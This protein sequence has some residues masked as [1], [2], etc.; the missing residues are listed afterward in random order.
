MAGSPNFEIALDGSTLG[1]R[2]LKHLL[3]AELRESLHEMDAFTLSLVVPQDPTEVTTLAKPGS[4]F[5]VK[6]KHGDSEREIKGSIVEVS[7]ARSVSAPW[8]VTYIGLDKMHELTRKRAKKVRK[9]SDATVVKEIA[10]ECGVSAEV[11]DVSATGDYSLQLN[12]DYASFLLRVAEQNDYIVRIEDDSTLRFSRRMSAYQNNP[13]TVRWGEHVESVELRASVREL[14]TGVKVRGYNP[15]KGEWVSG[16][17]SNSDLAAVD[18]PD[19]HALAA[20][21]HHVQGQGRRQGGAPGRRQPL[22]RGH[23]GVQRRHARGGERGEAHHQRRGRAAQRGLRH[24]RDRAH[25]HPRPGVPHDHPLPVRQ[26]AGLSSLEDPHATDPRARPDAVRRRPLAAGRRR[27]RRARAHGAG[28]P[29]GHPALAPRL[30][31]RSGRADRSARLG[32]V[33][34]R[35][36][37][38]VR[39]WVPGVKVARCH[40]ETA[41]LIDP[42]PDR[43]AGVPLAEA[44]LMSLGS[45]VS[46]EVSLDL[47]TPQ[48]P[49]LLTAQLMVR[50]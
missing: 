29:A 19:V 30:R 20:G 10:G 1:S 3:R 50:S 35:V 24:P 31:L 2:T 42:P 14:V 21:Q 47:E 43:P 26:P 49:L 8:V 36:E 46:L 23:G 9:G 34:W 33:R 12:E 27:D 4:S 16:S 40:V 38:A 15:A 28:D 41:S 25:A 22:R 6:L 17:A 11:E 39:R 44:A 32:E 13:V 7:H 37:Q 45:Q 5:S 18:V 48:G